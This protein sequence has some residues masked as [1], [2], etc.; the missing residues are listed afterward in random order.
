[1]DHFRTI[2]GNTTKLLG[3]DISRVSAPLHGGP[4]LSLH[5]DATNQYYEECRRQDH[6]RVVQGMLRKKICK[7]VTS[8]YSN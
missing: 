3:G 4:K 6:F 8:Y 5:C 7:I 1:M 2:G